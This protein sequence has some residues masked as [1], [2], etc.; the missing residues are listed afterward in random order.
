MLVRVI[1]PSYQDSASAEQAP[2][3]PGSPLDVERSKASM[4]TSHVPQVGG[5][6]EASTMTLK[7]NGGPRFEV[8][9]IYDCG[10]IGSSQ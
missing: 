2:E 1:T 10:K 5:F 4:R 6:T 8:A 9:Q 3:V 7:R